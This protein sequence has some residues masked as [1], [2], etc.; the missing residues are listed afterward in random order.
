[1]NRIEFSFYHPLSLF[2][3]FVFILLLTMFSFNP[4]LLI[5]SL[6]GASFFDIFINRSRIK[7]KSFLIYFLI[8]ISAAITNPLFSHNGMTVLF[9]LRDNA[10][11]VESIL[12]GMNIALMIISVMVWCKNYS[13]CVTQDKFL[14]LFSKPAPKAALILSCVIRFIPLFKQKYH[15]IS[16]AQKGLG[17][18]ENKRGIEKLKFSISVF[19]ALVTWSLEKSVETADSMK[20]RGYELKDKT[21]FSPFRFKGRDVLFLVLS[22]I[23][24]SITFVGIISE[25]LE[26][27]FYP[28]ITVSTVTPFTIAGA[29]SFTV[30][31]FLPFII[32]LKEN[33]LWKYYV[34]KI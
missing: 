33:L 12:Y 9:Y 20:S 22:L 27:S 5:I 29:A 21:S 28:M 18:Y 14:Y 30:F 34:S 31:S 19:S 24:V 16:D 8:F 6:L 15:L 3:Y 25:S 7:A 26:F 11:T 2:L 1:M 23:L 4:V 32:E 10:V 17:M 13:V